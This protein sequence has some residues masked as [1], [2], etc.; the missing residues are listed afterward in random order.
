[1]GLVKF[2]EW[3]AQARGALGAPPAALP[4][5]AGACDSSRT[6]GHAAA[7]LGFTAAAAV[8]EGWACCRRSDCRR[9]GCRRSRAAAAAE[10]LPLQLGAAAAAAEEPLPPLTCGP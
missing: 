3:Q 8:G 4:T 10:L 5:A 7:Q 2:T 1:M 6:A 9:S